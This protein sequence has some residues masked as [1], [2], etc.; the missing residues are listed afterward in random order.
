MLAFDFTHFLKDLQLT[1]LSSAGTKVIKRVA[2]TINSEQ[3][4]QFG[5]QSNNVQTCVSSY[6]H[7]ANAANLS[8]GVLNPSQKV[9]GQIRNSTKHTIS[10]QVFLN[11]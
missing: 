2:P 11:L 3:S 9:F 1:K 7:A 5:I 10:R 6:V 8:S 4:K